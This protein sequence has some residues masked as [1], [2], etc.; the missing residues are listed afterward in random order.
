MRVAA[1]LCIVLL[2]A[3]ALPCSAQD[4]DSEDMSSQKRMRKAGASGMAYGAVLLALILVVVLP[5]A[6]L[7]LITE[8]VSIEEVGLVKCVYTS[9]IFFAVIALIF[10]SAAGVDKGLT[11]P[12]ELFKA[13][14]LLARVAIVFGVSFL[15]MRFFL[16]GTL[17]RSL[18][19]G[20]L[21]VMGFYGSIYLAYQIIVQADAQGL[22]KGG[23][24]G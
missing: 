13:N 15:L 18:I 11:N 4:K 5:S 24:G 20:L 2:L 22:L 21:Y 19:S 17:V 9:L 23:M 16:S 3:A 14:E 12:V 1:L 10:Y 6:I 7:R 8:V